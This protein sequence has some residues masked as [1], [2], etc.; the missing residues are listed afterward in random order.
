MADQTVPMSMVQGRI[1]I[2]TQ[3]YNIHDIMPGAYDYYWLTV[4]D[5]KTL[6][7]VANAVTE[8]NNVVPAAVKKYDGNRQYILVASSYSKLC[9]NRP[10]GDLDTFLKNN[11]AGRKY[12]LAQQ[13]AVQVGIANNLMFNYALVSIMGSKSDAIEEYAI[14]NVAWS[15]PLEFIFTDNVYLPVTV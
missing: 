8:D 6:K 10:V 12:K 7:V 1:G 3:Q 11:G 13:I 9:A 5:S 15:L 2:G 14:G 4:L